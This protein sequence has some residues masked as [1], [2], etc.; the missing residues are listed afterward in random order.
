[1][2]RRQFEFWFDEGNEAG[3]LM[4]IYQNTK[5]GFLDDCR[6][7]II[8]DVVA[9]QFLTRTGRYA[10]EGDFRAW[11]GSLPPM[12]RVL[13]D[14]EI[15]DDAGVAI[16]YGIPG[17]NKRIDFL[18]SG[19]G[20]LGTPS[21]IVIELKQ[22]SSS[23][24]SDKDGLLLANRGGY[25]EIEGTHPSYQAWSYAALLRGFNEAAHDPDVGLQP[26]AYLHN[27]ADDGV[28]TDLRYAPYVDKAPVFLRGEAEMLRLRAFVRKHVTKGDGGKLLWAI[29]KGRL[30][31]SKMLADS[32]A[33][34]LKGSPEFVLVD[35]QKVVFESAL[36]AA[37]AAGPAHKQVVIVDGGPGTGKSVVALHLLSRLGSDGKGVRY[38]SRNAAPRKVYENKLTGDFRAT[39]IRGFFGGLN[40][41]EAPANTFDVLVI[42]EAHRLTEKSGFFGNKGE[43]QVKE[44]IAAAHCSVFFVD[45]RQQVT[46]SDIGDRAEIERW[47]KDAGATVHSYALKSQ[48]RCSGSNDFLAWLDFTLGLDDRQVKFDGN[49][50]DFRVVDSPTELH[51]LIESRNGENRARVVAGYCWNW[52]SKNDPEAFDIVMPEFGYARQWNLSTD[53]S[54][55]LV[56]PNSVEQVGC[57]HTC[58]GLE[59]DYVGVIVGPDL[60][61]RDGCLRTRVEA[62]ASQDRTVFGWRRLAEVDREGTAE[63]VDR[64]IRN[65]YRTLMTRGIKGCFVYC[66]DVETRDY[67]R[68]A[69]SV[70]S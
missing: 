29:E 64:I 43:N 26:C 53:G 45:D 21:L 12:Q 19:L 67:F 70:S 23:R 22:W 56:A 51:Q 10:P 16:E 28:L 65:T 37:R 30:R 5:I 2:S 66:T 27:H 34:M 36:A 31:P 47:A 41:Y 14:R 62:R 8:E 33:K 44:L 4:L 13:H 40:F 61:F 42:D 6:D 3:G 52:L 25:A 11:R 63:R 1:V 49:E 38:V 46:M 7:R 48:F 50:F 54:L 69:L 9:A 55:W 35:D 24:V 20:E 32:L 58:Q 15:P 18:I 17:S 39:Q 60:T 68:R 57:I 59:V